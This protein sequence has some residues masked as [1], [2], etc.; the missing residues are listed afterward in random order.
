MNISSFDNNLTKGEKIVRFE[1]IVGL[2]VKSTPITQPSP[3]LAKKIIVAIQQ[4]RKLQVYF[5]LTMNLIL[6][7]VS[8]IG[9]VWV[10][11]LYGQSILNSNAL[12]LLS[13]ILSD[14]AI[15]AKY[16]QDYFLSIVESLPI[17]SIVLVAFFFWFSCLSLWRLVQT[18]KL[19]PQ[20]VIKHA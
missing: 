2:A 8:F 7:A 6:M 17:I 3:F 13:L 5:R 10:W 1:E 4:R 11:R 20:N 9:F 15:V 12:K 16:W 19:L 14:W 18:L